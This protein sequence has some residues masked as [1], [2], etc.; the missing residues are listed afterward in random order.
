M[1]RSLL[2]LLL[3]TLNVSLYSGML[4]VA[5]G[6]NS[7]LNSLGSE[8][9]RSIYLAK[10]FRLSNLKVIPLNLGIDN[11]LRNQFEDEVL[12]ENRDTLAQNWL[13]AHYLGHHA[14]K[15]FKSQEAI[16]EFLSKVDNSLGYLDED[17]AQKYHLKII[18]RGKE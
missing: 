3:V 15:V 8:E 2:F 6:E 13:Q 11:P 7:K 18:F 17:V 5:V 10:R 4:V 14:P 12:D 1:N 9:I 16:A